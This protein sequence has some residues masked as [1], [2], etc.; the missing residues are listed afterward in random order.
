MKYATS[1]ATTPIAD[2]AA[3]QVHQIFAETE[4][5]F[6]SSMPIGTPARIRLGPAGVAP[7]GMMLAR[8]L[9]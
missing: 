8:V 4:S 9:P 6:V 2:P 3:D 7:A 1:R 5:E